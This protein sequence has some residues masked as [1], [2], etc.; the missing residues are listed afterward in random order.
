[1]IYLQGGAILIFVPGWEQIST[2]YKILQK[3][4]MFS[5]GN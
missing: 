5:N 2:L 3:D 4:R 1:M